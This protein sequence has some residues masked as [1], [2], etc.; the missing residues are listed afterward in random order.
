MSKVS[1]QLYKQT[2]GGSTE[3]CMSKIFVGDS[4]GI[5]Y[6]KVKDMHF[7]FM[8]VIKQWDTNY[9]HGQPS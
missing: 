6:L 1:I 9:V 4:P 7:P 2:D 5:K 8:I 3:Q